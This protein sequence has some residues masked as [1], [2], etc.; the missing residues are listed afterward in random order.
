M[1]E[2]INP[3]DVVWHLGSH[4]PPRKFEVKSVNVISVHGQ[5]LPDDHYCYNLYYPTIVFRSTIYPDRISAEQAYVKN[6]E[7]EIAA[8]TKSLLEAKKRMESL[9]NKET[10]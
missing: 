7:H 3:G 8:P 1:N 5:F 10:S 2:P 6:L 9:Y 4:G